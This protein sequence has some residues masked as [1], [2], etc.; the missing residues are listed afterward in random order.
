V[1]SIDLINANLLVYERAKKVVLGATRLMVNPDNGTL[2]PSDYRF[3]PYTGTSL[4]ESAIEA[5]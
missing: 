3:D 1:Y 2:Y 4:A 5:D